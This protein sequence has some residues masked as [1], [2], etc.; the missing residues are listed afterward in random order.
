MRGGKGW[1]KYPK[2]FKKLHPPNEDNGM[3]WVTKEEFF[4]Y[5][6]TICVCAMDINRLKDPSYANDLEDHF[7]REAP[8]KARP[9]APIEEE[10]VYPPI[11]I[12]TSSV[13]GSPYKIVEQSFNGGVSYN[14]INKKVVKAK[15]IVQGVEKFKKNPKKYLAIHWQ[16]SICSQ[17]WPDEVHQFTYIYREGTEDLD[18]DD[19]GNEGE[20]TILTNVL[21]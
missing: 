19:A 13:P 3:C 4:H 15:S 1:K 5:F 9:K 16:R 21:R 12:D 7:P 2:V 8:E 18:V 11:I 14:K 6:P 10:E 20:R 17:G